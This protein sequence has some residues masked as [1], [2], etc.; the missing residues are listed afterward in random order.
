[1]THNGGLLQIN[2]DSANPYSHFWALN[3]LDMAYPFDARTAALAVPNE[4]WP[5]Q[6]NALG[7][8][9]AMP[10]GTATQWYRPQLW[11]YG[12]VGDTLDLIYPTRTSN[13]TITSRT[14]D[15]TMAST[16]INGGKRYTITSVPA[17]TP[18]GYMCYL[19]SLEVT[20]MSAPLVKSAMKLYRTEYQSLID[21]GEIFD[22]LFLRLMDDPNQGGTGWG[23]I[24]S[25]T[26][27]GTNN[28]LERSSAN[29]LTLNHISLI[30]GPLSA[31]RWAGTNAKSKN[32]LTTST[33]IPT[34]PASLVDGQVIQFRLTNPPI[35]LIS[36]N[37]T[38]GNPTAIQ[39]TTNHGL[40][41]GDEI[42]FSFSFNSRGAAWLAAVEDK[43][44]V[45]GIPPSF[46]VTVT[47]L[48][49]VTIP[50]DSTGFPALASSGFFP[51]MTLTDGTLPAKP[52][53]EGLNTST[54]VAGKVFTTNQVITAVYN[55]TID[56]WVFNIGDNIN[57]LGASVPVEVCVALTNKIRSHLHY[58]FGTMV[59]S[60]YRR[61]TMTII[62]NSLASGLA[63]YNEQGN[64]PW[65]F[66]FPCW[67]YLRGIGAKQTGGAP[68]P[69][70]GQHELNMEMAADAAA[71]YGVTTPYKNVLNHQNVSGS[72]TA[73]LRG[74]PAIHGGNSALYYESHLD[75]FET[76]PYWLTKFSYSATAADY[77]GYKENIQKWLDG[78]EIEAY[79][80]MAQEG[81]SGPSEPLNN[82]NQQIVDQINIFMP[83]HLAAVAGKPG[84]S[85]NGI[86]VQCYEGDEHTIG[87][88]QISGGF[89]VD[90]ITLQDIEDFY[91]AY[92][93][94]EQRAYVTAFYM[95]NLL[96]IGIKFPS[97]FTV[98]GRWVNQYFWGAQRVNK[99]PYT[100]TP[101]FRVLKAVNAGKKLM[102]LRCVT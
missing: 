65:N 74:N 67:R 43:Q 8:P 3:M 51:V 13:I 83:Q 93:E 27:T 53:F 44:P 22:P 80:W 101:M 47:G 66:G 46:S 79:E 7:E 42:W 21:A 32:A 14:T 75:S 90:G 100:E 82:S 52:M 97:Q 26:F 72:Y 77:T 78:N 102:R 54:P 69:T 59:T 95:Q 40:S 60:E 85:G 84:R 87:I 64:E 62:K 92:R 38:L 17:E 45:T 18:T 34:L 2:L 4:N 25:M 5:L 58:C 48:D 56:A 57:L 55:A 30:G 33:R 63:T 24:R 36:T 16:N 76:A 89:P 6:I 37:I 71:I 28:S 70:Y 41:N 61:A 15:F 99:Y 20:A 29:R 1:M 88:P 94:S 98:S 9:Q 86:E 68:D 50:L 91:I 11:V 31:D 39:F 73:E 23:K 19:C 49:T 35:G 12:D 96:R 10:S 81:I